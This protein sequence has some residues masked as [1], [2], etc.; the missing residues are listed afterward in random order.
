M[1][2][3]GLWLYL[4]VRCAKEVYIVALLRLSRPPILMAVDG[5]LSMFYSAVG[6]LLLLGCH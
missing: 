1:V 2:V 3:G 5:T 6:R 4:D